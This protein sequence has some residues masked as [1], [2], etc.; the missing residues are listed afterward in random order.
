MSVDSI[1]ETFEVGFRGIGRGIVRCGRW[2]W[3][4]ALTIAW[5]AVV[6][7]EVDHFLGVSGLF[8]L[9]SVTCVIASASQVTKARLAKAEAEKALAETHKLRAEMDRSSAESVAATVQLQSDYSLLRMNYVTA[10]HAIAVVQGRTPLDRDAITGMLDMVATRLVAAVDGMS[11]Q[12]R[13]QL[14]LDAVEQLRVLVGE[15]ENDDLA[16]VAVDARIRAVHHEIEEH[17]NKLMADLERYVRENY[18]MPDGTVIVPGNWLP[19]P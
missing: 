13:A 2:L 5:W 19:G 7:H 11:D 14:I 3:K 17:I 15:L 10:I 12:H 8:L 6:I 9:G 1:L 18:Q 4:H 16:K